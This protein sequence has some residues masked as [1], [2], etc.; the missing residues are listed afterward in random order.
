MCGGHWASPPTQSSQLFLLRIIRASGGE[1]AAGLTCSALSWRGKATSWLWGGPPGA[2]AMVSGVGRGPSSERLQGSGGAMNSWETPLP[3]LP[4]PSLSQ[5]HPGNK[6]PDTCTPGG[7]IDPRPLHPQ[8]HFFISQAPS[9]G[10][11]WGVGDQG[12]HPLSSCMGLPSD[13]W[14]SA[15]AWLKD[16]GAIWGTLLLWR[17]RKGTR[18]PVQVPRAR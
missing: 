2:A 16:C 7:Q 12:A 1:Q 10:S 5:L 8:S 17:R 4:S 9:P 15:G 14:V 3:M 6:I 11:G 13:I 18:K